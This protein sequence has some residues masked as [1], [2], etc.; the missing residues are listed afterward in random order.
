MRIKKSIKILSVLVLSV[1]LLSFFEINVS[2]V[3]FNQVAQSDDSYRLEVLASPIGNSNSAQVRLDIQGA[4]IT[5]FTLGDQSN[6]LSIGVCEAGLFYT[7]TSV[8]F[9]AATI[10]NPIEEGDVLATIT[11]SPVVSYKGVT[12]SKST[13]NGY[14]DSNGTFSADSGLISPLTNPNSVTI[15]STL[16]LGIV[17]LVVAIAIVGVTG[18]IIINRFSRQNRNM[19]VHEPQTK[20]TSKKIDYIHFSGYALL[21]LA[22]GMV[23][24]LVSMIN[25]LTVITPEDTSADV[26]NSRLVCASASDNC[27][28]IGIKGIREAISEAKLDT[29]I[30]TIFISPGLY[31][32]VESDG[33]E[34]Y[35]TADNPNL[36]KRGLFFVDLYSNGTRNDSHPLN[37]VGLGKVG[38]LNN[39]VIIQGDA[40]L[41]PSEGG[42]VKCTDVENKCLTGEVQASSGFIVQSGVV[43]FKN[44]ELT[45]FT[46]YNAKDLGVTPGSDNY[47]LSWGGGIQTTGSGNT[48]P[49][50]S[51]K[52]ND[53]IVN[54]EESSLKYNT[55][56][57]RVFSRSKV[58]LQSNVIAFNKLNIHYGDF[59]KSDFIKDNIISQSETNN[60]YL[61]GES[62]VSIIRNN[63]ISRARNGGGL[64]TENKSKVSEITNNTFSKNN[65]FGI[66]LR[67][68]SLVDKI[69]YNTFDTEDIGIYVLSRPSSQN[70]PFLDI[71][72]N[73][74][75]GEISPT[76]P[77]YIQ[78]NLSNGITIRNTKITR[79]VIGNQFRNLRLNGLNLEGADAESVENNIFFNIN[80]SD[81]AVGASNTYGAALQLTNFNTQPQGS[82]IKNLVNNTFSGNKY[83]LKLKGVSGLEIPNKARIDNIKNNIFANNSYGIGTDKG[84]GIYSLNPYVQLGDFTFT[85]FYENGNGQEHCKW[86][87]EVE[88]VFNCQG[89]GNIFDL[90]PLFIDIAAGDLRLQLPTANSEGSPA[91]NAGRT[92]TNKPT[93][94]GAYGGDSY[95]ILDNTLEGCLVPTLTPTVISSLP[96]TP[97]ATPTV[98]ITVT[99][100]PTP[101]GIQDTIVC[102]PADVNSDG[103]FTISDFTQFAQYYYK[104]CSDVDPVTGETPDIYGECGGK[105]MVRGV[106]ETE[107]YGIITILDLRNFASRYNKTISGQP[108]C[109]L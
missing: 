65:F 69:S 59:S 37:I 42:F 45:G 19:K 64:I 15:N 44:I 80:S 75:D 38:E 72:G 66:S 49:V 28:Y 56:G 23:L 55:N 68:E 39:Q 4:E 97:T 35:T 24:A 61:A 88:P 101:T 67:G 29:T 87:D 54:I 108:S 8:C 21:F 22:M 30:D 89:D 82:Y 104:K 57:L 90:N 92:D 18:A 86:A 109:A 36:P 78:D 32:Y 93:D 81:T 17:I 95:C 50:G 13:Q 96:P 94:M 77:E 3:A 27:D 74:F 20:Q 76:D 11:I 6:Y 34:T 105:N 103:D 2:A 41:T 40:L 71:L 100:T 79:N 83:G 63:E 58:N 16:L 48:Y 70:S 106:S 43:N 9:D 60:I 25:R 26:V 62:F 46:S 52:S 85:L 99:V 33:F 91:I 51:N 10:N 14:L 84:G 5:D 1:F 73:T 47:Y 102:G 98:S 107:P 12:I 7:T 31:K 53:A